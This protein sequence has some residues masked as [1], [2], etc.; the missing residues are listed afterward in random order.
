M[1]AGHGNF[2]TGQ[3]SSS[4]KL[5]HYHCFFPPAFQH[6]RKHFL[7]IFIGTRGLLVNLLPLLPLPSI[8]PWFTWH[9]SGLLASTLSIHKITQSSTFGSYLLGL[10]VPPR[11]CSTKSRMTNVLVSYRD[12]LATHFVLEKQHFNETTVSRKALLG[13]G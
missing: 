7:H 8:A 10:S 12:T 13:T 1:A 3:S 6:C 5:K 9:I 11:S 2:T 4:C